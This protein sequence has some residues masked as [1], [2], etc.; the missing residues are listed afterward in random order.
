MILDLS[1][2][3]STLAVSLIKTDIAQKTLQ[4]EFDSTQ[5]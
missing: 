5:F 3:K 4:I 1:G 2:S